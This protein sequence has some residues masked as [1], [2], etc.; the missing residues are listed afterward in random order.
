MGER[1]TYNRTQLAHLLS[2]SAQHPSSAASA[3]ITQIGPPPSPHLLYLTSQPFPPSAP[4]LLCRCQSSP[5]TSRRLAKC[6]QLP[7][8]AHPLSSLY[9]GNQQAKAQQ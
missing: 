4:A 2:R 6:R 3:P 5:P 1:L 7:A 8:H 9:P